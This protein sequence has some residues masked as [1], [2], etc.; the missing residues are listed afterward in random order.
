MTETYLQKYKF[1]L[2]LTLLVFAVMGAAMLT[3]GV[4]Y[5]EPIWAFVQ[6]NVIIYTL[7]KII[8]IVAPLMVCVAYLTYAERKII[9]QRNHYSDR[10]QSLPVCDCAH[11]VDCTGTGCLGGDAI[12]RYVGACQH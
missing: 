7:L 9:G 2:M 8:L 10:C 3:V 12:Y 5:W 6:G 1:Q 11:V 4:L